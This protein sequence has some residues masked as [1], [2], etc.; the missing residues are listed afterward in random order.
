MVE[1]NWAKVD[2]GRCYVCN[3]M[4]NPDKDIYCVKNLEEGKRIRHLWHGAPGITRAMAV[5]DGV[6]GYAMSYDDARRRAVQ[7]LTG[8]SA[9]YA[10]PEVVA[11]E[12][13][14]LD[15]VNR[16]EQTIKD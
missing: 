4:I 15:E 1:G 8:S 11:V 16:L 3:D 10:A 5:V 2:A 14:I 13:T 7:Y 6:H 9:P 12:Q